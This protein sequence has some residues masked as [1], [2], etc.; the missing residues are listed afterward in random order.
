MTLSCEDET[1]IIYRSNEKVLN[2]S[3]QD[4][5]T[6]HKEC[7]IYTYHRDQNLLQKVLFNSSYILNITHKN[8]TTIHIV[9]ISYKS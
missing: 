8:Y 6:N 9:N 3:F 7:F 2:Q 1:S 5:F 4:C